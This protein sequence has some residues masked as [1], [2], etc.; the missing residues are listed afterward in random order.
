MEKKVFKNRKH[1][2]NPI[3]VICN[4]CKKNH[5]DKNYYLVL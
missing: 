3:N 4:K 2:L 1:A 5:I